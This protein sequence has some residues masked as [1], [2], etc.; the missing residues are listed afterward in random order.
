MTPSF[1]GHRPVLRRHLVRLRRRPVLQDT[2]H[3]RTQTLQPTHLAEEGVED[4]GSDD[5]VRREVGSEAR[6]EDLGG[7]EVQLEHLAHSVLDCGRLRHVTEVPGRLVH[8]WG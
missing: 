6:E 7:Q 1:A 2:P 5:K 3:A 8:V 4:E